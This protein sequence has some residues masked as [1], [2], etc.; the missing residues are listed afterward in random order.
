MIDRTL[1]ILAVSPRFAPTNGADT[2]R[3]RLVANHASTAGW[4]VEVLCVEPA[5]DIGPTDPWLAEGLPSDLP[6]HRVRP[7]PL[8]GWGLRGLA[9]RSILPLYRRGSE[10]LA[11]GQFDL[12]FFSTTEFAVHLLGPLWRRRFGIPFCMDYQDPWVNDF[13]RSHPGVVPP[14]GR[15][16]F[17]L[18]DRFHRFAERIVAPA[19]SGFLSVSQGYL[20]ELAVRYGETFRRR[21]WLVR[22]FPAEPSEMEKALE[23]GS[24]PSTI[25]PT[26]TL[27][28][29]RYVGRGGPDL[30]KAASA[31]FDAWMAALDAGFVAEGEIRFQALGTS[32]AKA[33]SGT[34]TLAPLV[35]G[36]PLE[37]WVEEAPDRL[38]YSSAL[39]VLA[40]SDALVVFGSDDP[41]YTASKIYPY[42]LA[43]R[44]LLAVVHRRSP[45]VELIRAVGGAACVTF[46]EGI[47]SSQ[48]ADA[49]LEAW[50]RPRRYE[51][52]VPL[53]RA[54]LKPFTAATQAKEMGAWFRSILEREPHPDDGARADRHVR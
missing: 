35:A 49:I 7:L 12:V 24:G 52:P 32:Y 31:F 5:N 44:P 18:A 46:D 9:Q 40:Q 3:L 47:S 4:G 33:G 8:R 1:R 14:G 27:R 36:L 20:D 17:M 26:G 34:R 39:A 42:L 29:W 50:F 15:L 48:L 43:G 21:P 2:H 11:T 6:V 53:D 28:A 54:A 45:V 16:K 30:Q 41:A 25:S 19:C 22:P 38:N 51:R 10:L 37:P 23:S 13:Y